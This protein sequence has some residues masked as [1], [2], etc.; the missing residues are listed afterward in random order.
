MSDIN[1][2]RLSD[3]MLKEFESPPEKDKPQARQR[4]NNP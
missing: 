1:W 2:T 3:S 4:Q